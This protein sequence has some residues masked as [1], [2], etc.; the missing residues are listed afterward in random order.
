MAY[1][2]RPAMRDG[3]RLRSERARKHVD[4]HR[5]ETTAAGG[6]AEAK[7]LAAPPLVRK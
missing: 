2:A 1:P 7:Q 3:R 5:N 6:E 4:R